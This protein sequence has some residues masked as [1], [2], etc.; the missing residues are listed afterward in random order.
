MKII[1]DT[2][3]VIAL[4]D[5]ADRHHHDVAQLI[6]IAEL[7]IPVAILPEVDYLA[8]KYLGERVARA[9]LDDTT[10]GA[11]TYLAM[12]ASDLSQATKIMGLY[13]DIPIGFVDASIAASG[14]RHHIQNVLTL[15]RKHFSVIRSQ[16]FGYFTLL[17]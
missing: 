14:D 16:Q 7:I 6:R 17:P 13:S 9:F 1:A 4:L 15:D 12:E 11:F 8:T 5:Q 10:A 3:G 2:S